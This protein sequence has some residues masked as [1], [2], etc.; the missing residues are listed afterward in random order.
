MV[1]SP[2]IA[3]PPK[4]HEAICDSVSPPLSPTPII[5]ATGAEAANK[6]AMRA[7]LKCIM[8]VSRAAVGGPGMGFW[9]GS[10]V[11]LNVHLQRCIEE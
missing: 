1:R 9:M 3:K 10:K 6:K 11:K 7:L 2:L 4:I 5:I 8:D